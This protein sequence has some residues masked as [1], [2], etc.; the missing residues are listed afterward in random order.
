MLHHLG[1]AGNRYRQK[2][3]LFKGPLKYPKRGR[4]IIRNDHP[5][6]IFGGRILVSSA[7]VGCR[8][9]RGIL[10]HIAHVILFK[11]ISTICRLP[12]F[13]PTRSQGSINF[14]QAQPELTVL[15]KSLNVILSIYSIL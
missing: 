3:C 6:L 9:I 13:Y 14:T 8:R 12:F 10:F 11:T 15:K 5:P 2:A 4:I 1:T 7:F